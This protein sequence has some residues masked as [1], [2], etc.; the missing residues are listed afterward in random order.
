MNNKWNRKSDDDYD[1][2]AIDADTGDILLETPKAKPTCYRV[3]KIFKIVYP[4]I[5]QGSWIKHKTIRGAAE[6][7]WDKK[8]KEK[9]I[10]IMTFL[11]K[12]EE[13]Q[14]CPRV[15]SPYDLELKWDAILDFKKRNNL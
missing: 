12:N 7:L 8:G 2:P 13:N 5:D 11:K 6:R 10:N 4:N 1:L 3:F 14:F 9:I 15:F